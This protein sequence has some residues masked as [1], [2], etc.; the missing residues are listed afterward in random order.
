[1]TL[2][3]DTVPH[4]PHRYIIQTE[5]FK[6][7][8]LNHTLEQMNLTDIYRTLHPAAA[9]YSFFSSAPRTFSRIYHMV[10]H[11]IILRKFKNIEII[12][13]I[14]SDLSGMKLEINNNR[15]GSRSSDM[16]ILNNTLLN[17][18]WVKK[19]IKREMKNYLKTNENENTAYQNLW[20]AAKAI[21]RNVY[22]NKCV[23]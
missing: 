18:E 16:W 13:T 3:H 12:P 4:H 21:L 11:K 22:N 10:G 23:Y 8:E 14:F 2:M 6:M 19:E 15:E 17:N 20:D 7:L 1:M 9:E 5:N